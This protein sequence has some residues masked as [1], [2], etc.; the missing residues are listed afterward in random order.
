VRNIAPVGLN[1]MAA[2]WSENLI[3]FATAII[4][5][6]LIHNWRRTTGEVM[7]LTHKLDPLYWGKRAA[8]VRA[9]ASNIK[10]PVLQDLMNG[11]ADQYE[12]L[13]RTGQEVLERAG[14]V[15]EKAKPG[16]PE[17]PKLQEPL[18]VEEA[19]PPVTLNENEL[20]LELKKRLQALA[21]RVAS[22]DS[23]VNRAGAG[24]K[25][26]SPQLARTMR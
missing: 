20:A 13:A 16:I 1:R 25:Q 18:T 21:A 26:S 7:A 17:A 8:D 11:F 23:A 19:S 6:C 10:D 12:K 15:L 24:Q 9:E 2:S 14:V 4:E 22:N 3:C 5:F